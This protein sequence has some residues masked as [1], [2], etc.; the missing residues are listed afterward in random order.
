MSE[1]EVVLVE[2]SD[3]IATITINRP[4]KLNAL[5]A[6]VIVALAMALEQ[7]RQDP[8][9]RVAVLTGAGEK[10]FIAGADISEF[11]G[12][13]A[14]EQYRIMQTG[15]IY[16]AVERFPKPTIAMI[17]G[18]CLGGGCEVAM[19]CDIRVAGDKAKLGQ[20][21][22]NLGIIPAGGATQRLPRLVGQGRAMRLIYTGDIIDAAEAERIG[23]VD[24]VVPQDELKDHVMK[25]AGKIAQKSPASLQAAKET[26]R[27]AWQ[28][29][30]DAG[31]RF[32]KSWFGLLFSTEDK[33]EGVTAFLEKRKPEFKGK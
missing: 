21:E 6:Q 30:L 10:A 24:E 14:V 4:D 28:M 3:H 13:P 33:E 26:V 18:F 12:A 8:D 15:D 25:L 7:L 5:D 32:E 31:L 16:S 1:K 29:P 23:L 22:T 2:K 17:N 20:P 11:K 9:V 19:A 27:A